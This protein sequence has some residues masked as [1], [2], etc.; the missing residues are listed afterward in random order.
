MARGYPAVSVGRRLAVVLV[1][2]LIGAAS[3]QARVDA[4]PLY[5]QEWWLSH[6]GADRVTPPGPGVPIAIVDSGVDPTH[7][8]FANRPNTSFLNNQTTFGREEFHGTAVASV[9][10]A[11][12]NGV[13]LDGVYPEAAL[14]IWDGSPTPQGISDF[15]AIAGIEAVS[16]H[17]P[18]VINISFGS[19]DPDP[20]LQ[21]ALLEAVRN[22]C[23]VVAA[24]GNNGQTGN[25]VT[26]PASWPH[27]FTVGATD[28]NDGVTPFSTTGAGIDVVAPGVAFVGAVPTERNSTGYETGLAGTSFSAPVVTAAAAWVWTV[29][30]TLSAAQVMQLLRSTARDIGPPGFDTASGWGIVDIP[31]A[32]AAP[33]PPN[34]PSEPNDDIRQVKPGVLFS[35]GEPPLT[36]SARPS[37]R[38]AGTLDQSEDP[39]DLYRIFVPPRRFVRVSTVSS[40]DAAARI[41]GPKTLGV[42]EGLAPRRR[43]LKGQ[44]VYGGKAGFQA[45]VEVLLT[46]R[47]STARYTLSVTASKK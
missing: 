13:G 12:D 10:A 40:G 35:L 19:T 23:L 32:L 14:E 9:A 17:C 34:D 20:D 46:G 37:T 5:P 6:V 29:R 24:A 8:E 31:A 42:G 15:T 11:P 28:E 18:A 26:Y 36:S 21:D 39:R 43:D 16:E 7:E 38:V 30:P 41:W 25:P 45:Y 33:T 2:A 1:L 22:G 4:D 3:A 27:I 47:S 44:K